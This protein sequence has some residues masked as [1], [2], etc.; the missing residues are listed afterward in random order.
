MKHK[1]PEFVASIKAKSKPHCCGT[2]QVIEMF[3]MQNHSK[4]YVIQCPCFL[5]TM[6]RLNLHI[7]VLVGYDF[8]HYRMLH[9]LLWL[10][11]ILSHL[12]H[13][14]LHW[15]MVGLLVILFL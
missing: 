9:F 7:Q 8:L 3:E 12:C 11:L 5:M 4:W 1:S 13:L 15:N 6:V 2:L 14:L 10:Q